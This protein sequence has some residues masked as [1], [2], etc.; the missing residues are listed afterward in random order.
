MEKY[1]NEYRENLEFLGKSKI[2]IRNYIGTA[3]K[4]IREQGI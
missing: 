4:F 2:T 1:L 3:R